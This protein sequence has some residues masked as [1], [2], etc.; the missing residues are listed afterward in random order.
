MMK[1]EYLH[2]GADDCPLIRLF[3]YDPADADA[4]RDACLS[5][6]A[7]RL[8]EFNVHAQPWAQPIGGCRL[9][10]RSAT[11]GRGVSFPAPGQP[12]VMEYDADGWLE[13]AEKLQPFVDGSDGFQWLTNEGDVNVLISRDGLW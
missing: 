1:V 9:L 6:A 5:L 3:D 4:L 7:G 11:R 8:A 12:F 10:L 2:S 13:V